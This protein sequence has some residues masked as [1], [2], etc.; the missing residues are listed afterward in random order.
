MRLAVTGRRPAHA[1][2]SAPIRGYS[3]KSFVIGWLAIV[4][5]VASAF[6]LAIKPLSFSSANLRVA[7]L[8]GSQAQAVWPAHHPEAQAH[9]K[10]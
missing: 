7:D 5:V 8:G 1:L 9:W 3:R 4:L 2:A 10:L 6:G